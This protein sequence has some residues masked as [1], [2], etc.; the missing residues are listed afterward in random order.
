M[1]A[2]G[3][4]SMY[5]GS[6]RY[7]PSRM[8]RRSSR[9]RPGPRLRPRPRRAVYTEGMSVLI[10]GKLVSPTAT[11]LDHD[12][13]HV[14]LLTQAPGAS[15]GPLRSATSR[16]QNAV[17]LAGLPTNPAYRRAKPPS[18][19]TG[20]TIGSIEATRLSGHSLGNT[21]LLD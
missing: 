3:Q 18:Y 12:P 10:T 2:H 13:S 19:R 11:E 1:E 20:M 21:S 6:C 17:M 9:F 14:H 8:P 7:L 4:L 16:F 15:R 5:R